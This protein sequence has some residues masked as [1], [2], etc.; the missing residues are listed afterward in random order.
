[1]NRLRRATRNNPKLAGS[2]AARKTSNRVNTLRSAQAPV[3]R[4]AILHS[5]R[6]ASRVLAEGLR[7]ERG[8]EGKGM[9]M[10][11]ILAIDDDRQNLDMMAA[12]LGRPE[13]EIVSSTDS[14]AALELFFYVRPQLVL[15][16]LMMPG[17][18][19]M[20]LLEQMV[21]A[22][23]SVDVILITGDYSTGSAVEAIQKGASD[24]LTKPVDLG[25]L[26]R[27]VADSLDEAE[28]RHRVWQ[29]DHEMLETCQFEGII[30]RAP[31]MWE[32]FAK[33]QRVAPHFSNALV[34]GPTGSGKELVAK[35]LHRRSSPNPG[36]F[37]ACNCSA[38]AETLVETELFG[39]VRGA[40]TGATQ[41]RVGLFEHADGGTVFLD[42]IGELAPAAQAKLLRVLQNQEIQ[43]VGAPGVRKVNVRVIAA[44]NRDLRELIAQKRFR[45][46][47]YYRLSSVEIKVPALAER[48]ED[49]PLLQRH[50]L[51]K[52]NTQYK[53][54]IRGISRRAR[55][56]LTHYAWPGN[57]RELETVSGSACMM[58]ES[59]F[60]DVGDLPEQL[61]E[62][63]PRTS[64][65][66]GAGIP[67]EE[68]E[69][70]YAREILERVGG[71]KQRA[72]EILSISR[73]TLYKLLGEGGGVEHKAA[74]AGLV[75]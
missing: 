33:V 45:D 20:E 62:R 6:T 69:R 46:D 25:K 65:A 8:D 43:R 56:L 29:L 26:R 52:F 68:M 3:A 30:G 60:I 54:N 34:T 39:H 63:M 27:R 72:A 59:D 4:T 31:I 64:A 38:I 57:V 40:F 2:S 24:Y 13:V 61:R 44:T 1:M 11:K 23:A 58:A 66:D 10:I 49:L 9:V 70:R 16:D 36:R 50:F 28:R 37:A 5:N 71:N 73:T 51:E 19:G 22:D 15:L 74:K 55:A 12:A 21:A 7:H 47:L 41:D 67:L 75:Q 18:G 53:K 35:A 32:L 14:T 17:I 48:K 42:E